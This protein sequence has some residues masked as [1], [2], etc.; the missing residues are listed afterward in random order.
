M[1]CPVKRPYSLNENLNMYLKYADT[2][3][4]RHQT[5]LKQISRSPRIYLSFY[6][7]PTFVVA[8]EQNVVHACLE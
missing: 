5:N 6:G 4:L 8:G 2:L 1:S 3:H 7:Y